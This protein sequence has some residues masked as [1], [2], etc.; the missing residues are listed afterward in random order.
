MA[1]ADLSYSRIT[2]RPPALQ[3]GFA[4]PGGDE[5]GDREDHHH[6]EHVSGDGDPVGD[7]VHAPPTP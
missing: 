3:P 5:G 4:Q 2:S 1:Q 6:S 7:A